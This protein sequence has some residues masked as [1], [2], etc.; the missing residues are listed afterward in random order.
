MRFMEFAPDNFRLSDADL[1]AIRSV[2]DS[3]WKQVRVNEAD[4]DT[5]VLICPLFDVTFEKHKKEIGDSFNRFIQQKM[6]N[7]MSSYSGGDGPFASDGPLGGIMHARMSAD[8][9]LLYTLSGK[10]PRQLKLYGFFS[11]E[12]SGTGRPAKIALQKQLK[13]RIMNQ[14][15]KIS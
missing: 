10:H 3:D 6:H 11:H 14:P 8:I 13:R 15:F 9:R 12:E 1:A 4:S 2:K 5:V 7:P